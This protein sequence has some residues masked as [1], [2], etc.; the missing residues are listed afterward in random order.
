MHQW[1][2]VPA[3][4]CPFILLLW[5][6]WNMP[7]DTLRPPDWVW[8]RE[9]LQ[10]ELYPHW[11]QMCP[12]H[13]WKLEN[14]WSTWKKVDICFL[15]IWILTMLSQLFQYSHMAI[16]F[17]CFVWVFSFFHKYIEPIKAFDLIKRKKKQEI[18]FQCN[19]V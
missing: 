18:S 7:R 11:S 1:H 10:P 9:L 6:Q 5:N 3:P 15:F 14:G 2:W 19:V 16:I 8:G 12:P 13:W 4:C 17:L